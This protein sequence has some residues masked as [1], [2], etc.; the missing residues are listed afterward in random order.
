MRKSTPDRRPFTFDRVVRIFFTIAGVVVIVWF[1]DYIK[2]VLL[3]F[4]VAWLIAYMLEPFVQY[5][6]AVLRTRGRMLAV[7]L[8]LFEALLMMVFLGVLFLPSIFR[9]F[10]QV[11]AIIEEYASSGVRVPFLSEEFHTYLM[12]LIDFHW[13]A[14]FFQSQGIDTIIDRVPAFLAQG[15]DMVMWVVNWFFTLLYVVFIMLDYEKLIKGIRR[16]VPPKYRTTT[17]SIGRDVKESMNHYFRGQA[18]VALCVGIM[19]AIGF[20]IVGLPLAVVM[21]LFIGV[22]NMVPYMQFI[23]LVPVTLLCL[24]CSVNTTVDFWPLWWECMAVY[25]IVQWIQDLVLTPKIM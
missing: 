2:M 22:L 21:G 6:R 7:F 25:V 9:E 12:R 19:F 18:L 4:L 11:G 5:N 23:S 13:L 20:S 1:I 15:I 14:E 24:V 17:F 16:M 10:H 3:P 8:T